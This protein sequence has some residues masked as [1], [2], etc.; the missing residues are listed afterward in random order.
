[1]QKLSYIIGLFVVGCSLSSCEDV[2]DVDLPQAEPR[3]VID[4]L[5]RV[6]AEEDYFPVIVRLSTTAPFD[7]EGVPRVSGAGVSLT[8]DEETYRLEDAGDGIYLGELPRKV[9]SNETIQLD[10]TYKDAHYA[11]TT[12]MVTTVAIDNL[13][14]GDGTLFSGDETEIIV[15]YTDPAPSRDYYLF[16]MDFGFY[17]LSEDSFYQGNPINFSYFYD[18]LDPGSALTIDILGVDKAFYDYMSIVISQ[19]GQ[20]TAGPF[21]APPAEV[22]GNIINTT[23]PEN[24]PLGYFAIAQQYSANIITE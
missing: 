16:D 22:K 24:Y 1:M 8:G 12:K 13:S 2:I 7:A 6:P 14:Q 4:A 10:I 17:L 19:T 20:D 15:D 9:I 23:N 3:L 21:E 11:S 18:N 5:I